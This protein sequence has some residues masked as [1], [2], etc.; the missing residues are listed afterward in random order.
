MKKLISLVLVLAVTMAIAIYP[1]AEEKRVIEAPYGTPVIDGVID[2]IWNTATSHLINREELGSKDYLGVDYKPL[3]NPYPKVRTLWDENNFY[4]LYEVKDPNL[5]FDNTEAAN[6]TRAAV[7]FYINQVNRAFG[8][9]IAR[10]GDVEA[11]FNP[12][13]GDLTINNGDKEAAVKGKHKI[14]EGG[15]IVEISVPWNQNAL[16]RREEEVKSGYEV[17]VDFMVG[18]QVDVTSG[19]AA[20]SKDSARIIWSG[21][22]WNNVAPYG[23]AKLVGGPSTK[24]SSS[25]ESSSDPVVSE[26]TQVV[27]ESSEDS[28]S[29]QET[30][31]D[32]VSEESSS[33]SLEESSQESITDSSEESMDESSE[34]ESEAE[35]EKGNSSLGIVIIII[36]IILAIAAI[37]FYILKKKNIINKK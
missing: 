7:F 24:P 23:I 14:V 20:G 6:W 32:E 17:S 35:K 11:V 4:V 19:D 21:G 33:A 26:P 12:D 10:W 36:I 13:N 28:Q 37:A 16:T 22:A 3:T 29:S 15:Y 1:C 2:S 30:S 34:E 25:T 8:G 5:V 18:T 9:L 27:S 31:S